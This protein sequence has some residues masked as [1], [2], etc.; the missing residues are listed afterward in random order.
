LVLPTK[1]GR[2]FS[3]PSLRAASSRELK[4]DSYNPLYQ[5][6]GFEKSN[7]TGQL[8]QL[9]EVAALSGIAVMP[10]TGLLPCQL[11]AKRIAGCTANI[12]DFPFATNPFTFEKEVLA[13]GFDVGFDE[14]VQPLSVNHLCFPNPNSENHEPAFH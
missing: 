1:S 10:Q 8:D 13:K 4:V 9:D 7:A 11:D 2:R 14:V 12:G 6:Y 5:I 3:C